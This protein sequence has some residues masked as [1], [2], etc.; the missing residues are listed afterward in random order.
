[1]AKR[2]KAVTRVSAR[3]KRKTPL[4]IGHGRIAAVHQSYE[5]EWQILKEQPGLERDVTR[6]R[7]KH[8]YPISPGQ[9]EATDPRTALT[10]LQALA[11]K[12]HIPND[13][14]L[15]FASWVKFGREYKVVAGD[16][17]GLPAAKVTLS[18]T[19]RGPARS[20]VSFVDGPEVDQNNRVIQG[21]KA[22][23][24]KRDRLELQPPPRPTT[25]PLTGHADWRPLLIW[26]LRNPDVDYKQIADVIGYSTGTVKNKLSELKSALLPPSK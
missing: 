1:M 19:P 4:E 12:Y 8:G 6:Y 18:I 20:P 26:H 3:P 11:E 25:D 13:Y 14:W 23:V 17:T 22:G 2:S 10:E 15:W 21:F 9:H 16:R 24:Q 7:N 5:L